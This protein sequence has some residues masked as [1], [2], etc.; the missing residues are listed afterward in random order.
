MSTFALARCGPIRVLRKKEQ[1]ES[2]PAVLV[3]LLIFV[4]LPTLWTLLM[5]SLDSGDGVFPGFAS[6][7]WLMAGG[8]F[9][10]V[11]GA[12]LVCRDLGAPTERF[13]LSKPVTEMQVLRAKARSGFSSLI[14]LALLIGGLE[15]VW[16]TF[17][18]THRRASSPSEFAGV[19]FLATGLSLCAYW[20]AFAA[21]CATRR[22]LTSTLAA[23][24]VLV[25][26]V[27]VPMIVRIPGLQDINDFIFSE[28]RVSKVALI[29][30]GLVIVPGLAAAL[31]MRYFASS[32][33]RVE[34]GT[35]QLA[36]TAALTLMVL[37]VL[38]M[39]EVGASQPLITT[40]W[41]PSENVSYPNLTAGHGHVAV[42]IAKTSVR[43]FDLDVNGHV[44]RKRSL[45]GQQAWE[46]MLGSCW[47][48]DESGNL[49]NLRS[50]YTK[51]NPE[52]GRWENNQVFMQTL[53]WERMEL[54]P[55]IA[56]PLPTELETF[57]FAGAC[58]T[59][60]G[61]TVLLAHWN[62]T[63]ASRSV[64]AV[65]AGY[66]LAPGT[67]SLEFR[68]PVNMKLTLDNSE[69]AWTVMSGQSPGERLR[70]S[71]W[72]Q[73]EPIASS[74]PYG[75]LVPRSDRWGLEII[76]EKWWARGQKRWAA[77]DK[78]VRADGAVIGRVRAS[79][80]AALFRSNHPRV[81]PAGPGRMVETHQANAIV[82]DITDPTRPRRIA[83]ITSPGIEDAAVMGDL[84]ILDHG[85]GFSVAKLPRISAALQEP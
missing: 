11:L 33:R 10:A 45:D 40:Q 34:L 29:A 67:P 15:L 17:E 58:F 59:P 8:L 24:F 76:D 5:L 35:R 44:T 46:L 68:H 22:S 23:I 65:I 83:H 18:P 48:F 1:I 41:Y 13:L 52:T 50:Q 19:Y 16:W 42:R 30:G 3:G 51:K 39:R 7:L 82:Y 28:V 70:Y 21:A 62:V 25:L 77:A 47:L 72:R 53:D 27:T 78:W 69:P 79:P 12:Q 57:G 49:A 85:A 73:L 61:L 74:D 56:L 84:L 66:R 54:S 80:W 63:Y 75:D 55:A 43:L 64:D 6:A 20:I 2:R 31:A 37:F 26:V 32:G 60:T 38:A 4:G 71:Q 14:L 36:W 9:S 81:L